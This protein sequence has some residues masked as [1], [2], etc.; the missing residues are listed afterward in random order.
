MVVPKQSDF[1]SL[2]IN[3]TN[4]N[5]VYGAYASVTEYK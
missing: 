1:G 2:L 3:Y 4:E 5:A